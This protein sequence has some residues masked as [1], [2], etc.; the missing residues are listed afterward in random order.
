M[1]SFSLSVLR[2]EGLGRSIMEPK[3]MDELEKYIAHFIEPNVGVPM[4]LSRSLSLA[5]CKF[6]IRTLRY[7]YME[8]NG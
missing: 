4:D 1:R 3:I 8:S 2:E 6:G 7:M 5:T